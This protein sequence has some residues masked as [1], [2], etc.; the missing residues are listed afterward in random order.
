M[1]L[2]S[3][4]LWDRSNPR[5]KHPK[6]FNKNSLAI[7]RGR[8]TA[9]KFSAAHLLKSP[10]GGK[11]YSDT[12]SLL[13]LSPTSFQPPH[14]PSRRSN[15]HGIMFWELRDPLWLLLIPLLI[16][17]TLWL[18]L[19]KPQHAVLYSS[20]ELVRHLP[21][22][23]AQ[24]VK[25]LL[26]WVTMIGLA[27]IVIAL[28]R[29]RFGLQ[30]SLIRS[31][32]IAIEMCIDR[33][34]SMSALD[35]SIDGRTVNRLAAVKE[36]IHD[37]IAGAGEL[38][39]RPDDAIGLV[40]FGGFAESKVPL[41]LD[42][43]VLLEVI[44][45][46]EIPQP[47]YDRDGNIINRDLLQEENATAIGDALMVAVDRIRKSPA[48]SRIIILLSDGEN[49][50]GVATPEEGAK[51]AAAS[52]VKVYA[53]GVGT[54]GIAPFPRQDAVGRIHTVQQRVVLD[55]VTLKMISDTTGGKYFNAKNSA[56]LTHI[57]SEI[58]QLEKTKTTGRIF[59][60]YRELFHYFLLPGLLLIVITTVSQAT[61]FRSL[62]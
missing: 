11:L 52:G 36:V 5:T 28:A 38:D 26:P 41:T 14:K 40:T 2:V 59:T 4:S 8:S 18:A 25:G 16:G 60:E 7:H 42:H 32:G 49:T 15:T 47:L 34:G 29:P 56:A 45:S 17:N 57:Y 30:E 62:P 19:R 55:E 35:F 1:I 13:Y 48:K 39:G 12:F 22:T 58:D 27:L 54:T 44:D 20:R 37:F 6:P 53:I 24:R 9:T 21:I 3:V 23:L 51:A 33:S 46:V 31:E 10:L 61:R 50:A 43:G